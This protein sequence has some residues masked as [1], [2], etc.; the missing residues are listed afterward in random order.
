MNAP[1]FHSEKGDGVLSEEG[2]KPTPSPAYT[3]EEL[4]AG[5]KGNVPGNAGNDRPS[6]L[7][8]ETD[9]GPPVGREVW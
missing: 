7:H 9:W 4:L 5:S 2:A 3:L 6:N 1:D 8:D